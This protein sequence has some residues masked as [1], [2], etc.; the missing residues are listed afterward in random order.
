METNFNNLKKLEQKVGFSEK[1]E[2]DR[3]HAFFNQGKLNDWQSILPKNIK[4]EIEK[5][6]YEEMK[7]LK[8]L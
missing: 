4:I 1:D 8:Y 2:K 7:E 5:N 3:I 6:F